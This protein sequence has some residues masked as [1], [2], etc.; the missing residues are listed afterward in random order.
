MIFIFSK[1][2]RK[3]RNK[4]YSQL[5]AAA[6]YL[7]TNRQRV[8]QPIRFQHLQWYTSKVFTMQIHA[9]K[10]AL[11]EFFSILQTCSTCNHKGLIKKTKE[12]PGFMCLC[13]EAFYGDRCQ[14]EGKCTQY[15]YIAA[16]PM[17]LH[18]ASYQ[19]LYLCVVFLYQKHLWARYRRN[20]V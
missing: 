10:V 20:V 17:Y 8:A 5:F 18:S 9:G 1:L 4:H 19:S 13:L 6:R 7:L 11:R 3:T 12:I 2:F 16:A 15:L 14:H